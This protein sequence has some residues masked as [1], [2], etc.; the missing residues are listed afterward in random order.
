MQCRVMG[1]ALDTALRFLSAAT[2]G[3]RT[4][5]PVLSHILLEAKDGELKM[6]ATNLNFWLEWTV[7]AEVEEDGKMAVSGK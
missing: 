5:L 7:A 6:A 3:A 1:S 4:T 2:V